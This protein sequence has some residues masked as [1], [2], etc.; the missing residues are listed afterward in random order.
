MRHHHLVNRE[1]A[2][3]E[4]RNAAA[5]WSVG[6]LSAADIVAVACDGLVAGLDGSALRMLAAVPY[7]NADNEAPEI[8]QAAL[9]ELGLQ[10]A[11]PGS[12]S[13][14]VAAVEALSARALAGRLTPRELAFWAHSRIGHDQLPLAE[15][16]VELD[17][18]YDCIEYSDQTA[19]ETDAEVLAEARRILDDPATGDE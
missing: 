1:D 18:V 3:T 16:L 15:G 8:L 17:D 13:A 9:E 2:A 5:L 19:E 4:L 6:Y 10:Y 7:R 12:R 11:P 14:L